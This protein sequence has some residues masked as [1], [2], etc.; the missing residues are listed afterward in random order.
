MGKISKCAICGR[1]IVMSRE[2][3]GWTRN[4]GWAVNARIGMLLQVHHECLYQR[5]DEVAARGGAKVS[6]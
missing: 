6:R 2:S 5:I 3:F 4:T 1:R